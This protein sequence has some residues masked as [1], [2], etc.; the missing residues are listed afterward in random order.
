[1]ALRP[2]KE[3]FVYYIGRYFTAEWYYTGEGKLPGLEYYSELSIQDRVR[4]LQIVK[5][6]CDSPYG[7]LFPITLYRIENKE[8]KVYAFKPR[9]ERFFNFTIAGAKVIIT[10]AYRKH[11]QQMTKLDLESLNVAIRYK[12]DYLRRVKECVYYEN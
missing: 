8:N 7:T 9:D 12:Q 11:S 6:Y 10:N 4:F 5:L 1:M 3:D 2:T